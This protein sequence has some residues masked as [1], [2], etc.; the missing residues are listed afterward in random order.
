MCMQ[1]DDLPAPDD[2]RSQS[3][4]CGRSSKDTRLFTN[5]HAF[6]KRSM[7]TDTI[8]VDSAIDVDS[9]IAAMEGAILSTKCT[10]KIP[11]VIVW[12]GSGTGTAAREAL[13]LSSYAHARSVS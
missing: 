12:F 11:S 4:S 5:G 10:E 3:S 7:H 6:V 13:N 8:G 1:Q 9:A 2:P